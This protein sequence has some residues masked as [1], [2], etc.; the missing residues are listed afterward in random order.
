MSRNNFWDRKEPMGAFRVLLLIALMLT[1]LFACTG[2]KSFFSSSTARSV[3]ITVYCNPPLVAEPVYPIDLLPMGANEFEI[4]RALWASV[5][6]HEA[7]SIKLRAAL[8]K[9]AATA[10]EKNGQNKN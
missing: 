9:C 8:D 10:A 6:M 1:I 4:T 3:P 5:E 7:Y 2:C